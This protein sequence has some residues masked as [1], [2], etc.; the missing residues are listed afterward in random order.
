MSGVHSEPTKEQIIRTGGNPQDGACQLE[1][2]SL[3]V[4]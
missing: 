3:Q 4:L 2:G 1:S